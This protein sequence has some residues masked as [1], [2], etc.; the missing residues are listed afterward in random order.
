VLGVVRDLRSPR[1]PDAPDEA[2]AYQEH[3]MAE[4]VLAR[5]AHGV[6]D[7]TIRGEIT[8]V[9]QFFDHAGVF[10]WEA[11][12]AHADRFL[13]QAQRHQAPQTRRGKAGAIDLFFRFLEARYPGRDPRADRPGDRL[14][15][16]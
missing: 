1:S 14:P 16:R 10:A 4:Y 12:P 6:T 11:E 3:L 8:A 15:D 9:E 7:G 2:A 5:L 13:G